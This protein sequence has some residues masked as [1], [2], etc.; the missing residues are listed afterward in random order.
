MSHSGHVKRTPKWI[1]RLWFFKP[2]SY[3]CCEL[4]WSHLYLTPS[5]LIS[6][7]LCSAWFVANVFKHWSQDSLSILSKFQL[8]IVLSLPLPHFVHSFDFKY[9]MKQIYQNY[10]SLPKWKKNAKYCNL[11]NPIQESKVFG[12]VVKTFMKKSCRAI[13]KRQPR[14]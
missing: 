12:L 10:Y 5:C 4:H 1:E 7:C 3:W 13:S 11:L 2:C 6:L 8:L 14:D 9:T